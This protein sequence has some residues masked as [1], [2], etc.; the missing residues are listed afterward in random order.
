MG[1][2]FLGFVIGLIFAALFGAILVFAAM[3]IGQSKPSVAASSA[4]ILHLEGDL[5]EQNPVDLPLP[6]LQQQQPITMLETWRILRDAAA[7]NRVKALVLEPRDLAAGWAGRRGSV[8]GW[9]ALVARN[10]DRR[11][12]RERRRLSS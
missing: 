3:R 2:F 11:S 6:F 10:R 5:P 1:K 12:A 7:D 9:P 8:P 4:L